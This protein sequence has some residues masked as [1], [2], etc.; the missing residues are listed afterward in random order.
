MVASH[1][2]VRCRS[3]H[4]L[5]ALI[6]TPTPTILSDELLFKREIEFDL[7]ITTWNE[8]RLR[9]GAFVESVA[10]LILKEKAPVVAIAGPFGEGKTSSAQ[11]AGFVPPSDQR[12]DCS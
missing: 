6:K 8:D 10:S 1:I 9:R 4:G 5:E 11:F 2:F 7:P 12:P 3:R